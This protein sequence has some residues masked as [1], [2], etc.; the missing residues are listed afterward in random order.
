MAAAINNGVKLDGDFN[1]SLALKDLWKLVIL[2]QNFPS[3][4]KICSHYWRPGGLLEKNIKQR[5][6]YIYYVY[7]SLGVNK[8]ASI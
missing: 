3:D 4:A 8:K 5:K 2:W 6:Y 7:F 1:R